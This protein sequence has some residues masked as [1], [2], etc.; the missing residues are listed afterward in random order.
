M[1]KKMTNHTWLN[2]DG[3]K[4]ETDI[5]KN[6]NGDKINY[7]KFFF[8]RNGKFYQTVNIKYKGDNTYVRKV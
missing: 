3:S 6:W 5:T 2:E 4:F 7:K 8:K 1:M